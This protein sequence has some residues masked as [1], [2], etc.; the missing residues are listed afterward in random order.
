MNISKSK[1][2]S[3]LET[4]ILDNY[5]QIIIV[6]DENVS[7]LYNSEITC[8][9]DF[10]P[11]HNKEAYLC[12]IVPG[13]ESKCI[14]MKKYIE[15][16]LFKNN[17]KRQNSCLIAIGGGVIGDLAGYVASTYKRGIDLIHVPTTLLA[18]VDS[19]IG[20]KNGINNTFGKN[21][22]GT[23]YQPKHILI[24]PYFLKTLPKEEII[25]GMAEIIKTA[26]I[27]NIK[28]WNTLQSYCLDDL[29]ND[30]QLFQN[31]IQETA[32][33]KLS[34]VENDFLDKAGSSKINI[35]YPRELLNFGHTIGH[36]IEYATQK[37]HGYCVAIGMVKELLF[38]K[39]GKHLVPLEIQNDIIDCLR[40]YQLPV[41]LDIHISDD[42]IETF[43]KNDKKD[44]RI[45][46]LKSIG[47]AYIEK[48]S[49]NQ[50][51]EMIRIDRVLHFKSK[52]NVEPIVYY[53][54]GSKSETNRVLIIAALGIG[55]CCIKNPLISDDTLYM[56][57]A[58][59]NLGIN[60]ELGDK[61]INIEGCAGNITINKDKILY[62]GNSGT[63]IRFLTAMTSIIKSEHKIILTGIERMKLR[64]I[65]H[66]V[67]ALKQLGVSI[68]TETE[69]G[70][71]PVIIF[72]NHE[73]ILG[74]ST[75]IDC[76]VS[77]QYLSG[78]LMISPCYGTDTK[79]YIKSDMVSSKFVKLTTKIMNK[80]GVN[81][82]EN[83]DQRYYLVKSQKYKNPKEYLIEADASSC[84]YPI[85]LSI[86]HKIPLHIPNLTSNN[87]QGDLYF[88]TEVMSKFGTFD[89]KCNEEG[90][91][92]DN[93][94][95][96]NKLC[97]LG[98][99]DMDSSDTFLTIGVLAALSNGTTKIIN[100][101]NQNVKE[102]ER[103][104]V[105]YKYL[106]E[107]GVDI[108]LQNNELEIQGNGGKNLKQICVDCHK[109]HRIAMSFAILGSHIDGIVISDYTCVN[110]TYPSFW[111]DMEIFGLQSDINQNK[112]LISK[113]NPIVLIGMPCSG[114]TYYGKKLSVNNGL[115][116]CDTDELFFT[117][118][119]ISP[120]DYISQYGW[121]N[122][123]RIEY[124]ILTRCLSEYDIISTGG[125][126]IEY[127]E[128]ANCLKNIENVIF[129]NTP[130]K[131]LQKR[132]S[133]RQ[134]TAPYGCT[135]EE[136]YE[137]RY[138]L[139]D[140]ISS[141]KYN[142]IDFLKYM[143][144]I[145]NKVS[146]C[147]NSCFI[148]IPF[149]YIKE[150]LTKLKHI[151]ENADALEIRIDYCE[152]ITNY[153]YIEE[154]LNKV[155]NIVNIPIIFTIRTTNEGGYFEYDKN[156]LESLINLAIK[157]GVEFIDNELWHNS[158]IT[159]RNNCQIIGSCHANDFTY[160]KKVINNQY[161][162]H[163]PDVLKLVVPYNIYQQTLD[164][165]KDINI[166][167]IIIA[168][169]NIGK[170]TRIVNQYY[171]PITHDDLNSTA[172]GQ[173][174]YNELQNMRNI[175]NIND[176]SLFF[177]FGSPIQKSPS[178]YIH[179]YIFNSRNKNSYYDIVETT[180]I[181][182]IVN[183]VNNKNFKGAS[184]TIPL[185]EKLFDIVDSISEPKK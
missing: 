38:K 27:G 124:I 123:R 113:N 53:G 142:G 66:L 96:D 169:K 25:N 174:T 13:E 20:G 50:I 72:N 44:G 146:I 64:P 109:D 8:F 56:I 33:T 42:D 155:Q 122:F 58:L 181:N 83:I 99:I 79:I 161:K 105:L 57:K 89:I 15:H 151:V 131:V 93:F 172:T 177:L 1:F 71:P 65:K 160:L 19:S 120:E 52:T 167:K 136:L 9:I 91:L 87:K 115:K 28:L 111:S 184:V 75:E 36:V 150:N 116:F 127:Q 76:S 154:I 6:T 30:D 5:Q 141:Y 98:T 176:E 63:S 165:V 162:K 7:K 24:F 110:K 125:G 128:S 149:I 138:N 129:I 45:V 10:F 185:K 173:L 62:L 152:D 157:N 2:N 49:C 12:E 182:Q 164:Y 85:A 43:F 3:I 168:S 130:L 22:I 156:I 54:P 112:K 82:V 51:L 163:N 77:S 104:N 46:L 23:F 47:H 143:N 18:M 73:N 29:L 40:K 106:K 148:C 11:E 31:I 61:Y 158:L 80:F 17:I 26:A 144:K 14:K 171:T 183:I 39:N 59:K 117:E 118:Y 135:I 21:M 48:C 101:D 4:E 69:S 121:K 107:A 74:G 92:I 81:V 94:K 134:Q 95:N 166:K 147:K 60:I 55:K 114:K 84:S 88:S 103:I 140:E 179:N 108:N 37:K 34:I 16:F 132:F 90:T 86:S 32:F 178:P 97:G 175:L 119:N 139:Y 159:N 153:K 35:K 68:N 67:L 70:C 170:L 180:M 126:I 137:K 133:E 145:L 102:C 41:D 100:I 78:L